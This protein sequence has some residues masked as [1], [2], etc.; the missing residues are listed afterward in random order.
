MITRRE[1]LTASAAGFAPAQ[2]APPRPNILFVMVDEMRWD[3]MGCQ[4][5]PAV[6]TPTLDKLASE[7]V[8]FTNTYTVSPVCCPSRASFFSGRYAHVHGVTTNGYPANPGEVFLPSIL[9]H[10][11]YHTAIAGKLHFTPARFDYGFDQFWSFTSEGPTPELGYQEYLR[12]KHGS[13]AKWPSVPGTCPWPDDPLGRDVGKFKYPEEDFETDWITARSIDYLRARKG[14]TQPWFLFTSYLKPHSPSVEPT[15]YFEM[16]DP[17]KVPVPKL[18]ANAHEVRMSK[19]ERRRRQFIDD[20]L[21]MRR[22]TALYFGAISHIDTHL[23]RLF[24]ELEQ[25]GMA[26]NTIVIFTSDHGNM[27]GDHG[28]W[29]KDVQ[30][31]GSAH[32]PLIWKGPKG[33]KENGGHAVEP[34]IE[35]TDVMP[36]LLEAAGLPVPEGVQGKSFLALA[37]RSPQAARGWKNHVYSQ[38]KGGSFIKDGYK[39][40]DNSLDGTGAKELY[41]LKADPKEM[42]NL[43]SD[44]AHAARLAKMMGELQKWRAVKPAPIKVSGMATPAYAEVG[45]E[46]R[47]DAKRNAP[48][49]DDAAPNP[50]NQDVPARKRKKQ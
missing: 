43:A 33:A 17:A 7:G 36:T 48:G 22:M 24:A 12:K 9:R 8:R 25:L 39:L 26:D 13:P 42:T 29:F 32:V 49:G 28:R 34:L 15:P 45:A 40:I 38:L 46:E 5:H 37:R 19:P 1:L 31:E 2:S 6:R 20:E 3:A 23:A 14:N 11:G 50:R 10:H 4:G 18:P 16:Y 21:M 41:H 47:E 44:P 35:T 30:Y 27:L